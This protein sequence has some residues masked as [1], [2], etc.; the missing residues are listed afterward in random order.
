[1]LLLHGPQDLRVLRACHTG[2]HKLPARVPAGGGRQRPAAAAPA[3]DAAS[4]LPRLLQDCAGRCVS[5]TA[6]GERV[7][8]QEG[9]RAPS[10]SS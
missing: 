9:G 4:H 7:R 10:A 5:C 1:M 6:A 2:A 3:A 8:E